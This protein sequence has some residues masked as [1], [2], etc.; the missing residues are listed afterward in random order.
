MRSLQGV[1]S[2]RGG[3][4][5]SWRFFFFFSIYKQT[6]CVSHLE[7]FELYVSKNS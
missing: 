6:E 3:F 4:Q 7:N 5:F 2:T 1:A